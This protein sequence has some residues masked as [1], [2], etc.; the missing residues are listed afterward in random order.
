MKS[1]PLGR[2]ERRN[3]SSSVAEIALL[4]PLFAS[5]SSA[6]P[7]RSSGERSFLSNLLT[8][9]DGTYTRG[10]TLL[11]RADTSTDAAATRSLSAPAF[12]DRLRCSRRPPGGITPSFYDGKAPARSTGRRLRLHAPPFG[13]RLEDDIQAPIPAGLPPSPAL[14]GR[15]AALT[16]SCHRLCRVV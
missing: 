14:S 8:R 1:R 3:P 16:R 15:R 13:W 12:F 11:G 9:R 5:S 2:T 7:S 10:T 6:C 4:L